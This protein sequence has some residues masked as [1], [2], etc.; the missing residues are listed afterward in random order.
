MYICGDMFVHVSAVPSEAGR[1]SAYSGVRVTGS[2]EPLN[3]GNGNQTW[4]LEEQYM[5]LT[6]EPSLSPLG[7]IFF[8]IFVLFYY[9]G[10]YM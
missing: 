10:V 8:F 7:A 2:C 5:F 4:F 3:M 1:A 6:H 9:F